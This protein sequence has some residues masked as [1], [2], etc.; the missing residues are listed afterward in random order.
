[1]KILFILKTPRFTILR[2]NKG[3]KI[4]APDLN[5][6]PTTATHLFTLTLRKI[7]KNSTNKK[8]ENNLYLNLNKFWMNKI[9]LT[10]L[11]FETRSETK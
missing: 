7:I 3:S 8:I 4:L 11:T 10:D 9:S 1:M 5:N 6:N 2:I